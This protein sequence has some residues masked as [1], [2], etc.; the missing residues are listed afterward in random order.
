M[1]QYFFCLE[2]AQEVP[3]P[4]ELDLVSI[5]N[6]ITGYN[7]KNERFSQPFYGLCSA[8]RS[9]LSKDSESLES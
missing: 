4:L 7:K 3:K 1:M 6:G 2:I 5:Y 8:P 9:I